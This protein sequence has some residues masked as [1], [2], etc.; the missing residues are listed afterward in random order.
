[1][2]GR[3]PIIQKYPSNRNLL[4]NDSNYCIN[5]S[6][7]KG[8]RDLIKISETAKREDHWTFFAEKEYWV[9][10]AHE[11]KER[12][13]KNGRLYMDTKFKTIPLSENIMEVLGK[14]IIEYHIHPDMVVNHYFSCK[15]ECI[16]ELE[17]CKPFLIF[18]SENDFLNSFHVPDREYGLATSLGITT[19]KMHSEK[20]FK[21]KSMSKILKKSY[22]ERTPEKTL[23]DFLDEYV[24]KVKDELGDYATIDFR[25]KQKL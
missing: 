19:Y 16:E 2:M 5:K 6:M 8:E 18:P 24:A 22:P 7:A 20:A 12:Y 9:H 1:M 23:E 4:I 17:F 10:V 13:S 15:P 14:R 21:R 11:H 3:N 25:H